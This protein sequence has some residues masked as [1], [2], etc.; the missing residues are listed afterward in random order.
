MKIC[1][2]LCKDPM[3]RWLTLFEAFGAEDEVTI[4]G[5]RRLS[6]LLFS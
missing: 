1:R 5:R 6:L 2:K 4:E 3:L